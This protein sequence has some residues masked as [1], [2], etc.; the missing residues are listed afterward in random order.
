MLLNFAQNVAKLLVLNQA[1]IELSSL[2]LYLVDACSNTRCYPR[3]LQEADKERRSLQTEQ[4]YRKHE[5]QIL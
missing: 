2:S 5:I 1:E 3:L 4:I